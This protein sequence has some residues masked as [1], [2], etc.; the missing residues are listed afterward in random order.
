M[1]VRVHTNAEQLRGL[2][3]DVQAGGKF[4]RK[5]AMALLTILIDIAEK[6][7]TAQN[8]I[9]TTT[10]TNLSSPDPRISK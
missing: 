6:M 1:E 5:E 8:R 9:M 3:E 7:E 2:L 4:E 10:D